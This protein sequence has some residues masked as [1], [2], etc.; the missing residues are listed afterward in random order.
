MVDTNNKKKD[1]HSNILKVDLKVKQQQQ[2]ENQDSEVTWMFILY[3]PGFVCYFNSENTEA[4][5][6]HCIFN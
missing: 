4:I 3:Q 5:N 6:G 2:Q 1:E